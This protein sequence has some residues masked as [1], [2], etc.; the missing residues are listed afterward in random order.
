MLACG[1][2]AVAYAAACELWRLA[3]LGAWAVTFIFLAKGVRSLERRV[4]RL[5]EQQ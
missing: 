3:I 4:V 2:A 5:C 1:G